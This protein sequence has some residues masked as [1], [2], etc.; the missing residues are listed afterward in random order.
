MIVHRNNADYY[1]NMFS[2]AEFMER[3]R[4]HEIPYGR[5]VNVVKYDGEKVG[6]FLTH[7]QKVSL[8]KEGNAQYEDMEEFWNQG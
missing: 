8:N 7:S 2:K 6:S 5:N 1:G 3:L 4:T